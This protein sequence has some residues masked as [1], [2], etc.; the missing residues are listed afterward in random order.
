MFISEMTSMPSAISFSAAAGHIG[1]HN[2]VAHLLV[3]DHHLIDYY[4]CATLQAISGNG[5]RLRMHV[6]YA[7]HSTYVLL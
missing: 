6:L 7:A 4:E 1:L 5:S 2:A 3:V